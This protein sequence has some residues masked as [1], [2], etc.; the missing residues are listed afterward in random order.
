[1]KEQTGVP[2]FVPARSTLAHR[3]AWEKPIQVVVTVQEPPPY[4]PGYKLLAPSD[5]QPSVLPPWRA[6]ADQYF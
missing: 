2:V 6:V 1:L 5:H 4:P 3:R